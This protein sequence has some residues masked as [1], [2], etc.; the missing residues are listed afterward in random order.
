VY[1]NSFDGF[2]KI[3]KYEGIS[4]FMKGSLASALKEGPFAGTYYV[5]YRFMKKKS[6]VLEEQSHYLLVSLVSGMTAGLIA[7]SVS[8]P[9]EIIRARL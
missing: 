6:L 1:K 3:L 9:F 7:T 8:H 2:K 4:S 5:I